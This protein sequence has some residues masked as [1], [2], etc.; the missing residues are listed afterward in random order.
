MPEPVKVLYLIERLARAGTE[1]HLVRLLEHLNRDRFQ[2]VLCCL[3]GDQTDRDLIPADV[4]FHHLDAPWNLISPATFGV[5]NRLLALLRSERPQILHTFLFVGNVLGPFAARRAGAPAVVMSRGRM[6]IEWQANWLHRLAQRAANRRSH[7]LTVKTEAMGREIAKHEGVA[8]EKIHVIPNGVDLAR[9]RVDAGALAENRRALERDHKIPTD[10]PL[11]VAVGNLK[12]IKGHRTLVE[13]AKRL[14]QEFPRLHIA[15]VGHGEGAPELRALRDELGLGP[16]VAFPGAV[17]DVRPWMGAADVF[18]A[19][20]LSEGMPN[21]VLEAM[22]MGLPLVLSDIPGHREA[23]D[24][25]AAYFVPGDPIAL[26]QTLTE[27][28]R[29]PERRAERGRAAQQR[30]EERFSI[31]V[32]MHKIEDLYARLAGNRR[33]RDASTTP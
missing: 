15:V 3:N 4:P 19:P 6:G 11:V 28:L 13:A 1:L 12:P 16:R 32:M 5:W 30:V 18:V 23:A 29:H 7:T 21:A 25:T 9:F 20:S 14:T 27:V 31:E 8:P 22:A 10:G 33:P 2:P 24:H 26:A 17:G